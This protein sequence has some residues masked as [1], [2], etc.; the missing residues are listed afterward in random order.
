M[1]GAGGAGPVAR[2]ALALFGAERAWA[3]AGRACGRAV[4]GVDRGARA[5]PSA[6][7]HG[8]AL[9]A[10]IATPCGETKFT[11]EACHLVLGVFHCVLFETL[12][13][14]VVHPVQTKVVHVCI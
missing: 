1:R 2:H 5:E 9:H 11:L 13:L 10:W 3:S 4:A 8:L 7:W 6:A 14:V 12:V